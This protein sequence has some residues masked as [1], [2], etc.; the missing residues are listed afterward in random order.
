[1]LVL[2][3]LW[4]VAVV[5]GGRPALGLAAL[6]YGIFGVV[7]Y[8]LDVDL[9][10][11]LFV[12][13]G[14]V[15]GIAMLFSMAIHQARP[16]GCGAV[17]YTST[18]SSLV[19]FTNA[20]YFLGFKDQDTNIVTVVNKEV[21]SKTN[22][23]RRVY[24]R[25]TTLLGKNDQKFSYK[26]FDLDFSGC[27]ESGATFPL[28]IAYVNNVH[29]K[30]IKNV[31]AYIKGLTNDRVMAGT[32]V[33]L[34]LGEK[35]VLPRAIYNSAKS[36]GLAHIIVVSGYNLAVFLSFLDK[37]LWFINSRK[38]LFF[39]LLLLLFLPRFVGLSPP[40]LR[41]LLSYFFVIFAKLIFGVFVNK[42]FLFV[43]IMVGF[44][45]MEPTFILDLSFVLSMLAT[46]GVSFLLPFIEDKVW[47]FGA[48][49]G[50]FVKGFG[51]G[52]KI[53]KIGLEYLL[54]S[55][56]ASVFV[57]PVLM[58]YFNSFGVG[59]GDL[60]GSFVVSLVYNPLVLPIVDVLTPVAYAWL[61][62]WYVFGWIKFVVDALFYVVLFGLNLLILLLM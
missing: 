50:K 7:E 34:F 21:T 30:I 47:R 32:F 33:A 18:R 44:V 40:V 11:D 60:F 62:L 45:L 31:Y 55:F 51:V 52:K 10:L 49:V 6:I 41:A 42:G 13:W 14:G 59:K 54:A 36:K 39:S 26:P 46:F 23:L 28:F 37:G 61:L 38:R 17:V 35:E 1:V 3:L 8:V 5:W 29:K 22:G 53:I 25:Y 57:Y 15:L 16:Q 27:I 20:C 4:A 48:W 9:R 24:W 2:M 56:S 19:C 43:L 58:Y 12:K